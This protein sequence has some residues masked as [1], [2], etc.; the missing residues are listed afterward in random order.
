MQQLVMIM[1]PNGLQVY[2]EVSQ[3]HH[4]ETNSKL[5]THEHELAQQIDEEALVSQRVEQYLKKHYEQLAGEVDHWMTRHE[6]DLDMKTRDLHD[7]K[8]Q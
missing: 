7:L 2:V 8:V 1:S 4:L 3:R 6:Q 5:S